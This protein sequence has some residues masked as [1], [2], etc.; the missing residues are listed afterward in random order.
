M[1]LELRDDPVPSFFAFNENAFNLWIFF[2]DAHVRFSKCCFDDF[3]SEM[4]L[5]I[6]TDICQHKVR[7]HVHGQDFVDVVGGC[8]CF[9]D[10]PDAIDSITVGTFAN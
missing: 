9:Q 6:N 1:F 2:L 10:G 5:E 3:C 8:M 7:P 4:V